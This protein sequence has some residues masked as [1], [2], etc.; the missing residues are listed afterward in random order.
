MTMR[1]PLIAFATILVLGCASSGK[2]QPD[3]TH[4]IPVIVE[5]DLTTR[6][7]VTVRLRTGDGNSVVLGGA[8]PGADRR[9]AYRAR[10]LSGD[11]QLIAT[12]GDGRTITSRQFTLFPGTAV[13]W[14]LRQNTLQVISSG[15]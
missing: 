7:D 4:A 9:F 5:N 3:E 14:R 10:L 1:R 2:E 11:F 12:T 13:V 6:S 8:P 15:L